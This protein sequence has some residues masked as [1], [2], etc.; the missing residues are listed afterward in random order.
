MSPSPIIHHSSI[1]GNI[2]SIF[3]NYLKN[4]PCIAFVDNVDVHFNEKDIFIPDVS[5]VCNRE[6]IKRTG[7]FGAPD[8]VVEVLSPST[9]KND[10]GYKKS[11]Y[12]SYGVKEYWIVDPESRS[13]E[14]YLLKNDR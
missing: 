14:V 7:I 4:K 11:V 1:V 6:I 13:L 5:I 10:R 9:A 3:K 12:E 2:Y 8:L